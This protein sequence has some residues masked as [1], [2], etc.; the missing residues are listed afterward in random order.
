M[1]PD[2]TALTGAIC[3]T[4]FVEEARILKHFS[5]RQKQTNFVV[6]GALRAKYNTFFKRNGPYLIKSPR[7]TTLNLPAQLL[8]LAKIIFN[9][10][11]PLFYLNGKDLWCC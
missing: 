9:L 5:I 4:L 7:N 6:L 10:R 1:A 11:Q 3:S 2:Q 8:R